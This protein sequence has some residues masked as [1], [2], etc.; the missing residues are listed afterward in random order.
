MLRIANF[1][2]NPGVASARVQLA[3]NRPERSDGR[4]LVR[5]TGLRYFSKISSFS[6]LS[7]WRS[8]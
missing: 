7:L 5:P 2:G 8:Y 6:I 1:N 3:R 4:L